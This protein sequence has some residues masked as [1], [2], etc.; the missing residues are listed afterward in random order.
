MGRASSPSSSFGL[1]PQPNINLI[2]RK[3]NFLPPTKFKIE[4]KREL[5][6]I[7][8]KTVRLRVRKPQIQKKKQIRRRRR[9]RLV[10]GKKK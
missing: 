6:K 7:K 8:T 10:K 5:K 1:G 4:K 3:E 2:C 9:L